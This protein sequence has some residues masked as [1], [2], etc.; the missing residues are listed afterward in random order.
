M[1]SLG[2]SV[3]S[4]ESVLNNPSCATKA[5][6]VGGG[7]S[8]A[9]CAASVAAMTTRRAAMRAADFMTVLPLSIVPGLQQRGGALA[10]GGVFILGG[11]GQQGVR[12]R[13]ESP[14]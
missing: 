4:I 13:A 3:N 5:P 12:S 14:E 10:N 2:A 8:T 7:G 1:P 6:G 11:F 9:C